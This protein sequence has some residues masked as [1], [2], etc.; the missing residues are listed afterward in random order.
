MKN[1]ELSGGETEIQQ[2]IDNLKT[3]LL[4]AKVKAQGDPN[5]FAFKCGYY[6]AAMADTIDKLEDALK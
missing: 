1:K 5:P 6:E 2:A 4:D 3:S